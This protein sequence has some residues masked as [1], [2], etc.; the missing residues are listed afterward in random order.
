MQ[1]G[2][3][4]WHLWGTTQRLTFQDNVVA[5]S[6]RP[7]QTAQILD[8]KYGRPETWKFAF[9]ATLVQVTGAPANAIRVDLALTFGVG[10]SIVKIPTFI[11]WEW[12]VVQMGSLL[13][14]PRLVQ[15]TEQPA[16]NTARTSINLVETISAETIQAQANNVSEGLNPGC[17]FT[18]DISGL[19]T[20]FTHIR[21]EWQLRHFPGNEHT[22]H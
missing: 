4:P 14:V 3:P 1:T 7:F 9:A 18:V 8:V 22:G 10:R 12:T 11:F 15:S 21:P 6:L 13:N 5:G 17:T 16:E 19:V 2:T 20:P